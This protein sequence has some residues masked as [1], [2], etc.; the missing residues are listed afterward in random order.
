MLLQMSVPRV[1]LFG[2]RSLPDE[3]FAKLPSLGVEVASIPR[4]GHW[5]AWENPGGLAEAIAKV[6]ASVEVG[7]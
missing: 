1:V 2:E 3:D 7:K 5:M 4:A 6:V